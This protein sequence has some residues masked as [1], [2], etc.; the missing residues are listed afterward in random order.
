MARM[1]LL[2]WR[3]EKRKAQSKMFGIQLATGVALTVVG[4]LAFNTQISSNQSYQQSRNSF[5]TTEIS[6]LEAEL[7]EIA[8]LETTKSKLLSRMEIIQQL[9]A[10]RPQV[11]HLFHEIATAIPTGIQLSDL[12]Q[13]GDQLTLKGRTQSNARVSEFMRLLDA[14]PWMS[15]PSVKNITAEKDKNSS[16]FEL[17]L[18]HT[19]PG[20]K[21]P[22]SQENP[23]NG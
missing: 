13:A 19:A 6:A 23:F 18:T 10:Q 3:E 2:P 8:E 5:L 12:S 17:V 9:Q 14:S 15:A 22:D 21:K 16:T 4:C 1:N 20:T 11:V 7:S